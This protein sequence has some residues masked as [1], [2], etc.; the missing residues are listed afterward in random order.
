MIL[1]PTHEQIFGVLFDEPEC[2][3]DI[4][5]THAGYRAHDLRPAGDREFN[6]CLGP[7]S[8]HMYVWR[9]VLARRQVDDDAEAIDTQDGG[10]KPKIT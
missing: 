3:H 10:H 5:R 4:G 8:P 7:I 9:A 6:H 2:P 1:P